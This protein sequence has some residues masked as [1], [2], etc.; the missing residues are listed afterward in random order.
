MT[1]ININS[2]LTKQI[3]HL[4]EKFVNNYV[5]YVS[6]KIYKALMD[7]NSLKSIAYYIQIRSY[8]NKV[9]GSCKFNKAEVAKHLGVS[10]NTLSTHLNIL[11][12]HNILKYSKGNISFTSVRKLKDTRKHAGYSEKKAGKGHRKRKAYIK[13]DVHENLQTQIDVVEGWISLRSLDAQN[14]AINNNT[15]MKNSARRHKTYYSGLTCRTLGKRLKKSHQTANRRLHRLQK[16]GLIMMQRTYLCASDNMN[17]NSLNQ[18]KAL[19][20]A[21]NWAYASGN[22][23]FY[24]TKREILLSNREYSYINSTILY[25]KTKNSNSPHTP[26]S[27]VVTSNINE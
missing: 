15:N 18:L 2:E 3:E 26:L 7:E 24:E 14:N 25:N 8:C 10:Y 17:E 27:V 4:H 23:T 19:G 9:K 20:D 12:K 5:I 13:F 1:K 22:S 21:P 16:H 6:G 11:Q